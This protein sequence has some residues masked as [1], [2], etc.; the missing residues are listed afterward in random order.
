[1]GLHG[2]AIQLAEKGLDVLAEADRLVFGGGHSY[3]LFSL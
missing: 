1:M 3:V 2:I